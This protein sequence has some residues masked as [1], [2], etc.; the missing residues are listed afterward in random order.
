MGGIVLGTSQLT[1]EQA[2][3]RLVMLPAEELQNQYILVPS[4]PYTTHFIS[5][6]IVSVYRSA[7]EF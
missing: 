6:T 1:T 3:A 2:D 4:L 5:C 7:A